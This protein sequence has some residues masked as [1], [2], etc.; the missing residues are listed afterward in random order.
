M[1]IICQLMKTNSKSTSLAKS[2]VNPGSLPSEPDL[3]P[4]PTNKYLHGRAQAITQE[5]DDRKSTT[6]RT[7]SVPGGLFHCPFHLALS[8]NRSRFTVRLTFHFSPL[9][10]RRFEVTIGESLYF[11]LAPCDLGD[12]GWGDPWFPHGAVLLLSPAGMALFLSVF[13][14]FWFVYVCGHTMMRW[15]N[16]VTSCMNLP[17]NW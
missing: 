13:S 4:C 12:P 5:Q 10:L 14:P 6:E 11:L 7:L 3:A 1:N 15:H 16:V 8:H 9:S 17:M 2:T